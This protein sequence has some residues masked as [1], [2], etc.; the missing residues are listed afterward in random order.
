MPSK[1]VLF[2]IISEYFNVVSKMTKGT[3]AEYEEMMEIIRSMEKR[4]NSL[5]FQKIILALVQEGV[6]P[7]RSDGDRKKTYLS[8]EEI[9]CI[10]NDIY[11]KVNFGI[12]LDSIR[13]SYT[14]NGF[15]LDIIEAFQYY[16]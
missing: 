4:D 16:I 13:T 7:A 6:I 9:K 10:I 8:F 15:A 12:S 5:F 11:K 14:D 2:M 3:D 1:E